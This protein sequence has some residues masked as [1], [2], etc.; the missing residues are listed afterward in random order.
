MSA[1]VRTEASGDNGYTPLSLAIKFQKIICCSI[2]VFTQLQLSFALPRT[3]VGRARPVAT[4]TAV[5]TA[6]STLAQWR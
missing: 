4:A 5:P 2:S 1:I 6:A 3:L